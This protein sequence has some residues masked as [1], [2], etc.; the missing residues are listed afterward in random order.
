MIYD[1]NGKLIQ[2]LKFKEST[3]IDLNNIN[4]GMYFVNL[5]SENEV[6]SKKI[7]VLNE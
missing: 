3:T 5:I 2:F 1:I 7:F 6:L 4:N